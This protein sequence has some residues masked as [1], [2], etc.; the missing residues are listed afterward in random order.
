M[1]K[2]PKANAFRSLFLQV[3]LSLQ[4][5]FSLQTETLFETINA[6]TSIYQFLFTS[7]ERVAFRTYL[8]ANFRLAGTSFDYLTT[9]TG[10]GTFYIVRMNSLFHDCSPHF[11]FMTMGSCCLACTHHNLQYQLPAQDIAPAEQ[12]WERLPNYYTIKFLALSRILF[13]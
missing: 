12:P 2:D 8:Y 5:K 9:S 3:S 1:K 7:V 13:Y 10:N 6:S 11:W 4:K